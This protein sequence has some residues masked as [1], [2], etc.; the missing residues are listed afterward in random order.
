VSSAENGERRHLYGTVGAETL[1]FTPAEVYEHDIAPWLTEIPPKDGK[2][3]IEEHDVHP[4]QEH[5]PSATMLLDWLAEWAAEQGEL[6]ETGSERF[7]EATGVEDVKVAAQALIDLIASKV[8]Y[9]M[10][11]NR[12]R[13]LWLTWDADGH[14]L[15][16]GERL[17]ENGGR[18]A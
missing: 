17:Y 15:L 7:D 8:D 12:L 16:D 13:S 10:A 14:P 11:K 3:E 9:R 4:P 6:D 5:L 1:W 2:R 18:D